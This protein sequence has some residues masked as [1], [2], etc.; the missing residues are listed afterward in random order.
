M[1]QI[2]FSIAPD[3]Q[4]ALEEAGKPTTATVAVPII[5]EKEVLSLLAP[6]VSSSGGGFEH[7]L[8]ATRKLLDAKGATSAYIVVRTTQSMQYVVV[9]VSDAASA[10]NRMLYSTGLARVVEATPH[11]QKR[12]IKI[13]SVDELLPSLFESQTKEMREDLMTES[14]RQHS[15]IARMELA[16]MPVALPGVT[17]QVTAEADSALSQFAGGA[18]DVAIFKI[19]AGQLQLDKTLPQRNGDLDQVKSILTDAEPRFVLLRYPSPKTQ[20]AEAV[21]VYMCPPTCSLKIKIQYAS[22]AACFR[23]Q[24]VRHQIK[25][26][27]KVETD[28]SATLAEDVRSAFESFPCAGTHTNQDK[29]PS[30]TPASSAPKGHRMLI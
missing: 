6:P 22:S 1:L 16:P 20:L 27:H 5:I 18:L 19:A 25:F 24:A 2:D 13:S 10:K 8:S 29:L 12:T 23:E 17:V 26:A 11:A 9:Y 4:A 3:V 21:M 14:E 28:T 30:S 15:A 7:D